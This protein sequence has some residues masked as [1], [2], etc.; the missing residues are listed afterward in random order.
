MPR[1]T[2]PSSLHGIDRDALERIVDPIARAHGAEVVDMEFKTERG[3][4][5]LRIYVEKAGASDQRLSIRD[6]AVDLGL[7]A[8]VSHDL[9]PALDAIDLVPHAYHLE[10]SSPGVERPLRGERDFVRFGGQKAKLKLREPVDGQRVIIGLLDG[11]VAARVRVIDG[12][13]V[14]EVPLP[15]IDSARLIFEFG[16]RGK[17]RRRHPAHAA[18]VGRETPQRK[19]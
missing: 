5:V 6:A 19:H 8:D 14:V 9:S 12:V 17:E 2:Y 16:L 18:S 13:R 10:V 7:C 3:G 11:V 1:S 4:W 15:L